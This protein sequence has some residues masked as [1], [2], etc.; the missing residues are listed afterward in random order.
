MSHYRENNRCS[1]LR[2]L[3]LLSEN[4]KHMKATLMNLLQVPGV[5][6]YEIQGGISQRIYEIAKTISKSRVSLDACG[7]V[8]LEKGT[9]PVSLLLEAHIDEV[10]FVVTK[11]L[12]ET[13]V[14]TLP[15]GGIYSEEVEGSEVQVIDSYGE[16]TPGQIEERFRIRVSNAA[17]I[18][19]GNIVYFER[20]IHTAKNVITAP[21]LDNRVSCAVLLEFM[22][23]VRPKNA[24]V[25]ALFSTK[26]EIGSPAGLSHWIWRYQPEC[27]I[28]LDSA[29]AYPDGDEH[30][31]LP[32]LGGGPAIQI[33]GSNFVASGTVVNKLKA[34]AAHNGIPYQ[35]EIPVQQAGGTNA[36]KLP[37]SVPFGVVNIPVR[38]QHTASSQVDLRDLRWTKQLLLG[39]MSTT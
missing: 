21:A 22:K 9:G 17:H 10:G 13:T 34:A 14:Q 18:Q 28:V 7:N 8:A 11:N 36:S 31:C 30:W 26:H 20:I 12:N 15:I 33:M 5:T 39:V 16:V 3:V 29:Y 6:G 1:L 27:V 4:G 24:T 19:A 25:V 38:S 35:F 37:T 2:A 23:A 32:R